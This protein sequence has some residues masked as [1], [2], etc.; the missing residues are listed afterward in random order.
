[1]VHITSD[2]GS[3]YVWHM[4]VKGGDRQHRARWSREE[5]AKQQIKQGKRLIMGPGEG[6]GLIHGTLARK[7]APTLH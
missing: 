4:P 7:V 1:M 3:L 2:I 5:K 6:L